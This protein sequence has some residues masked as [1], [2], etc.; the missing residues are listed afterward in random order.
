M[1]AP[2]GK[3][4]RIPSAGVNQRVAVFGALDA[5]SGRV[6]ACT[7]QRKNASAFRDYLALL[8]ARYKG[9]HI[10]LFLDNC[11]IHHAKVIERF[12]FDHKAQITVIWNAAYTPE[13]NLIERYWGH[14]K[15]KAIN[16]YFFGTQAAL[17]QAVREAIIDLNRSQKLRMT[18][19]LEFLQTFRK[20]A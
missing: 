17:E 16:N 11:S 10:F 19:H 4:A 9:R 1:W 14:L 7:A 5:V 3:Q 15:A 2:I 20:T 12:L 8:C 13:L 18:V 6:L